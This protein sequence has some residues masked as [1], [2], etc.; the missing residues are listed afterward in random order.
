MKPRVG[1]AHVMEPCCQSHVL[2]QR[3][4]ETGTLGATVWKAHIVTVD[5]SCHWAIPILSI[6]ISLNS[7][8]SVGV[9]NALTPANSVRTAQ[10]QCGVKTAEE[11]SR[12]SNPPSCCLPCYLWW[13]ECAIAALARSANRRPKDLGDTPR[14]KP[15]ATISCMRMVVCMSQQRLDRASGGGLAPDR[16]RV[17][18]LFPRLPASLC[19]CPVLAREY[20]VQTQSKKGQGFRAGVGQLLLGA[21]IVGSQCVH[22]VIADIP[23]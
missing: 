23:A 7:T 6:G 11:S 19:Q 3:I 17:A 20:G 18:A 10:I 15:E 1:L 9:E 14:A 8:I 21:G 12:K 16:P 13:T 5:A 2:R 22:S 4:R